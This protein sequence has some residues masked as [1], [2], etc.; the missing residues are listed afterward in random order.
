MAVLGKYFIKYVIFGGDDFKRH[1]GK[2]L[3]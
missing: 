3:A 2:I 1:N